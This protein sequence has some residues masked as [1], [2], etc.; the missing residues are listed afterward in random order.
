MISPFSP[1][2]SEQCSSWR[3]AA[4]RPCVITVTADCTWGT[5]VAEKPVLPARPGDEKADFHPAC[6]GRGDRQ[7]LCAAPEVA[8]VSRSFIARA[9]NGSDRRAVVALDATDRETAAALD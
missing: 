6:R 7:N 1:I 4:F 5:T 3:R 9:P 8:G 2:W